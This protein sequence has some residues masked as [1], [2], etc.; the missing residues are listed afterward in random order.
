[1]LWCMETPFPA[2]C[3][4]M[5][6]LRTSQHTV[7]VVLEGQHIE[8]VCQGCHLLHLLD[9]QAVD[10]VA[11]ICRVHVAQQQVHGLKGDALHALVQLSTSFALHNMQECMS[12]VFKLEVALDNK[13]Q[14][15]KL[16][17]LHKMVSPLGMSFGRACYDTHKRS[18]I[19]K[20]WLCEKNIQY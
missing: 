4:L 19:A 10:E 17:S 20:Y 14:Y 8:A 3:I 7:A 1:M 2:A 15:L 18:W 16:A 9:G 12:N 13:E 6:C 5:H 11:G